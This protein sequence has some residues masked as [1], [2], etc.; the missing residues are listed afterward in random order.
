MNPGNSWFHHSE[1]PGGCAR[2]MDT[3]MYIAIP[4]AVIAVLVGIYLLVVA[5]LSLA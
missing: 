1:E 2:F 5:V 3:A 4:L